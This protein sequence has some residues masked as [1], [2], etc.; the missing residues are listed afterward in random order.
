MGKRESPLGGKEPAGC[1]DRLGTAQGRAVLCPGPS[2]DSRRMDGSEMPLAARLGPLPHNCPRSPIEVVLSAE[3]RLHALVGKKDG[4]AFTPNEE[5]K[6][7]YQDRFITRTCQ[8][9]F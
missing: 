3:V 4:H 1:G 2:G 5:M 8:E 6:L 7:D 9:W